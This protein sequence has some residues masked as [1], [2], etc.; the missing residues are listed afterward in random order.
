MA[1]SFTHPDAGFTVTVPQGW[2]GNLQT[3]D[4]HLH[5]SAGLQDSLW[6]SA[7]FSVREGVNSLQQAQ[8]MGM[9]AYK[10]ALGEFHSNGGLMI[11]SV[12][13]SMLAGQPAL[14]IR[15]QAADG[16]YTYDQYF[17]VKD[18]REI[19]VTLFAHSETMQ[20]NQAVLNGIVQSLTF[21]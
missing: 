12:Q 2:T 15:A 11:E 8:R 9:D 14:Q 5:P 16:L 19:V 18:G 3:G 1:G 4:F 13:P 20:N 6:A 17:A 7:T 10:A 21:P